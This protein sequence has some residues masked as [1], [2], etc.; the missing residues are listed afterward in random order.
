[1]LGSLPSPRVYVHTDV[2]GGVHVHM[3]GV[4]ACIWKFIHAC[5]ACI[6]V[7]KKKEWGGG[8]LPILLLGSF[9]PFKGH[10]RDTS[11]FSPQSA[12]NKLQMMSKLQKE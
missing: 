2:G 9:G 5:K 12:R 11:Q 7:T 8:K 3:G 6:R 4:H 1:M 10:R